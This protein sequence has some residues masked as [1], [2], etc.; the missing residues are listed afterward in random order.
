MPFY[1]LDNLYATLGLYRKPFTI[2]W[3]NIDVNLLN[4]LEVSTS[5]GPR[6]KD[7]DCEIAA[8]LV[9]VQVVTFVASPSLHFLAPL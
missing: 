3:I 8:S 9:Q 6:I 7:A 1:I 4:F 2:H 5:G